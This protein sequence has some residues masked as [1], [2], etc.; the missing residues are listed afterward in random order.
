LKLQFPHSAVS[1]GTQQYPRGSDHC[2]FPASS[3]GK[4]CPL[5]SR[6]TR[7]VQAKASRPTTQRSRSAHRSTAFSASASA[8]EP[9]N[10]KAR[11]LIA[12]SRQPR[13]APR[14]QRRSREIQRR[15]VSLPASASTAF[16]ASASASEP[17]IQGR[18][19]DKFIRPTS[20]VIALFKDSS[21]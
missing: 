18:L 16:S 3:A 20:F 9:R 19:N 17:R 4:H 12:C 7:Q 13:S 14:L 11:G 5:L 10:S 2:K 6:P 21:V 8:S 1:Q 15:E